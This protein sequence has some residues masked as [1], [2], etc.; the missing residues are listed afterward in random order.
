MGSTNSLLAQ[1]AS[2][3]LVQF[4]TETLLHKVVQALAQ[5]FELHLVDNLVDK[6]KLQEQLGL[7]LADAPLAHVEHGGIIELSHR[8]PMRALHVIGI[9]LQHRLGKH[10]CLT[11]GAEVLVYLVRRSLLCS[12]AYKN[13]SC[14]SSHGIVTKH[15]FI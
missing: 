11:C 10:P 13:L 1:L 14:E 4:S 3:A 15:I 9:Y 8:R 12:M 6:G 5:G 7:L 2:L